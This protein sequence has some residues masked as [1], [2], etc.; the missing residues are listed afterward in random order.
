[1]N[2]ERNHRSVEEWEQVVGEQVRN[3]RVASR[4]DQPRLAAL[5][6]VSVGALSNLERG[7]G[8]SLKTVVAVL[9]ALGRTDWLEALAPEVTVSPMQML[10]AKKKASGGRVRVRVR[11]PNI[12]GTG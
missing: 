10:R 1:M 2:L 4:L 12:S 11:G 6:N 7:R 3:A 5:A 9:R 8:S